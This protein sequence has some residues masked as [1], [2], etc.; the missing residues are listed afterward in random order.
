MADFG[1][2]FLV[3]PMG[4]GKSTVGRCLAELAGLK[5]IDSDAEI[6]HRT[7]A[8]IAWVFDVEGEA[9]FR[10]RE[11][12]VIADLATMQGIVL[13]T[14]G[15][16]V[17]NETKRKNLKAGGAV[18]YLETSVDQQFARTGRD[19]RRPLINNDSPKE[20]LARLMKE[21]DP[22]YRETADIIVKTDGQAAHVIAELILEELKKLHKDASSLNATKELE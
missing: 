19:K 4:A 7:G 17:K 14:G 9:G 8:D 5:F 21:R 16:A 10:K 2:I 6:E 15:G 12:Q 13:A 3:G 22:L 20:T 11:E 18:V 1:N